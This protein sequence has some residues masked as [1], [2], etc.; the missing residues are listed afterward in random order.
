MNKNGI[1]RQKT[2]IPDLSG[3]SW[4]KARQPIVWRTAE[5][6]DSRLSRVYRYTSS[7]T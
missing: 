1:V 6:R 5:Q 3:I 7:S 2:Y 4:K